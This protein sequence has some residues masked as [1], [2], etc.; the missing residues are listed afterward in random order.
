MLVTRMSHARQI[1]GKMRDIQWETIWNSCTDRCD[2]D[3]WNTDPV[4]D[5]AM[6]NRGRA[7]LLLMTSLFGCRHSSCKFR[8]VHF[9][10]QT[11]VMLGCGGFWAFSSVASCSLIFLVCPGA[12]SG[13]CIMSDKQL[14]AGLW[15]S[16]ARR[17]TITL[18][19]TLIADVSI[20]FTWQ[21]FPVVDIC[22]WL[23]A[24]LWSRIWPCSDANC[25]ECISYSAQVQI[26]NICVCHKSRSLSKYLWTCSS[27]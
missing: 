7:V 19:R 23:L 17:S 11:A 18:R 15:I 9:H 22:A 3:S 6:S 16:P 27:A 20:A 21:R 10:V 26:A 25:I 2:W 24:S 5:Q 12:D 1:M 14:A 8:Y 13:W 4:I